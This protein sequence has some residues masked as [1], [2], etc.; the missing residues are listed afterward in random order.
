MEFIAA[1]RE[2]FR[3]IKKF[4]VFV[5]NKRNVEVVTLILTST[6]AFIAFV[7]AIIAFLELG[8]IRDSADAAKQAADVAHD[9][10]VVSNRPWVGFAENPRFVEV[11]RA[12]P[13]G[14]EGRIYVTYKITA[15]TKNFGNSPALHFVMGG[16]HYFTSRAVD[17]SKT[18]EASCQDTENLA[19][20]RPFNSER[21]YTV[22]PGAQGTPPRL[23]NSFSARSAK[24]LE[25]LVMTQKL[26]II[27]CM[28]YTDQFGSNNVHHTPYCFHS[29]VA[30]KDVM[31]NHSELEPCFSG[32][33]SN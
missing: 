12:T 13:F 17:I 7:G 33:P 1:L 2:A 10:L 19:L 11:S 3:E 21:G 25:D 15:P 26:F 23:E 9:T 30:M 6:L 22:F 28:V 18:I 27:G 5:R 29:T 16:G 20:G 8:P 4:V 31:P 32:Y 24:E 14:K